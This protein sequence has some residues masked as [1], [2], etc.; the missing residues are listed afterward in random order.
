MISVTTCNYKRYMAAPALLRCTI[1]FITCKRT[2]DCLPLASSAKSCVSKNALLLSALQQRCWLSSSETE[3]HP[4]SFTAG[5]RQHSTEAPDSQLDP[6]T[7]HVLPVQ[8]SPTQCARFRIYDQFVV[9]TLQNY[10]R[11]AIPGFAP[12]SILPRVR[13]GQQPITM[14]L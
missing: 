1:A 14:A 4:T 10:L 12:V 11:R 13:F 2:A 9:R 3:H 7:H 5:M 8:P 6:S